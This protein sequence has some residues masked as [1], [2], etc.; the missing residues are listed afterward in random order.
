[1]PLNTLAL[2]QDAKAAQKF[3]FIH[4][5][6]IGMIKLGDYPVHFKINLL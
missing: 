4:E 3:T 1:M 6:C 2:L 5:Q